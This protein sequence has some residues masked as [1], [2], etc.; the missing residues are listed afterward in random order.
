MYT[1]CIL[2]AINLFKKVVPI[3]KEGNPSIVTH[4]RPVSLTS[5][6]C[7]QMENF[8][9]RFLRQVLDTNKW[10]DEGQHGFRPGYSFESQIFTVCQGIADS[11]NEGARIEAVII[12]F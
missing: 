7:T 11:L 12:E 8:I 4:Y 9:A 3:Y 2:S 10:L 1:L 5:A 6:V